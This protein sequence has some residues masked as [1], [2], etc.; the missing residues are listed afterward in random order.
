MKK[1]IVFFLD[2]DGV[3]IH[4]QMPL[5]PYLTL[6][7][8]CVQQLKKSVEK[9]GA[10]IVFSSCF[11]KQPDWKKRIL[12]SFKKAGWS[13]P[14]IIDRTPYSIGNKRGEEINSWLSRNRP[15]GCDYVIIDDEAQS[16]LPDQM[17]RLVRTNGYDGGFQNRHVEEIDNILAG[18]Q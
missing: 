9:H 6:D 2:L 7:P 18:Q 10:S 4:F 11:R 16:M 17:P 1:N 15:N 8:N 12:V 3:L 13:N 5:R 14:P